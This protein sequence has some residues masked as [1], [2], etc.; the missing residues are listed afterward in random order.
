[1][2]SCRNIIRHNALLVLIVIN[3]SV[4]CGFKAEKVEFLMDNRYFPRVKQ[5]IDS[6]EKSV[7]VMMFEASYYKKYPDSPSN[8]LIEALMNAAKRGLK[9]EVILDLRKNNERTTKRNLVT[10]E[11][12]KNAGVEVI[13][14]SKQITTHTKLLIIDST[15]IICGSTNWTYNALTENHEVSAVIHDCE[16]AKN[17]QNY[18]NE[19]KNKGKKL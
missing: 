19:V 16:S 2:W 9:V 17:L 12:L 7:Q 14:D 3:T 11:I 5:L 15:I 18:F 8:Q 13:L 1:M 10:G 6:A 4:S